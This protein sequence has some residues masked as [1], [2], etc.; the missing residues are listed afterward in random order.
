MCPKKVR[1]MEVIRLLGDKANLHNR[2]KKNRLCGF[3]VYDNIKNYYWI[4]HIIWIF[5]IL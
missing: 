4:I 3:I 5:R 1:R 2:V